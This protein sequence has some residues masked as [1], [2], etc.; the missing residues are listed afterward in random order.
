VVDRA[1]VMGGVTLAAAGR[2]SGE[3]HDEDREAG[4]HISILMQ[5]AATQ[6]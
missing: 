3:R 1:G 2:E 6:A 5:P 4:C